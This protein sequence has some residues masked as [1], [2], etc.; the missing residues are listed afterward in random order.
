M[1]VKKGEAPHD[2]AGL[3]NLLEWNGRFTAGPAADQ[4]SAGRPAAVDHLDQASAGHPAAVDH[5]AADQVSD[6]DSDS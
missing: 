4:A 5:L 1:A 2:R 6:L 3:P